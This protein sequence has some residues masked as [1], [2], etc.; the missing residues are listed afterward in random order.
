[1]AYRHYDTE[2]LI[3]SHRNLGEANRLYQILTLDFGLIN[4]LAQGVRHDRSKLRHHLENFSFARLIL[5]RGREFWRVVGANDLN[6]PGKPSR[7]ILSFLKKISLVLQ[8]LIHGEETNSP[9]YQDLKQ[10]SLLLGDGDSQAK[11]C[12]V[13]L[14]I[15]IMVRIL[16]K[17]GYLVPLPELKNIFS[18]PTFSWLEVGKVKDFKS[19]LIKQINQALEVTQL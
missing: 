13:D 16:I 3:I 6:L 9:I 5:V 1:M 10:A 4:V 2:G 11:D 18:P 17:L 8:R 14:E 19:L 7:E 12:L 15:F